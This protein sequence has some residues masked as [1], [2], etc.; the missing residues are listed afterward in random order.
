ML[1]R[2]TECLA[3]YRPNATAAEGKSDRST[4]LGHHVQAHAP[5]NFKQENTEQMSYEE[6]G[7]CETRPIHTRATGERVRAMATLGGPPCQHTSCRL[8]GTHLRRNPQGERWLC[9]VH[10][11]DATLDSRIARQLERRAAMR[12][13]G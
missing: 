4:V 10:A 1:Q 3:S 11:E 6:F 2:M 7:N 5:A 13:N 8:L 12:G 9:S